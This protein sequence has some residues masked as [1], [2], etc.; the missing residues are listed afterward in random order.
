MEGGHGGSANNEQE[1]FMSGLEFT[2]LWATL[3]GAAVRTDAPAGDEA[4]E[5]PAEAA[6]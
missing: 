6:K 3:T 5:A 1:A 4:G 2:F